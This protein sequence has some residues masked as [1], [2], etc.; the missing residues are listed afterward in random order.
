VDL[1]VEGA[2]GRVAVEIKHSSSV[3]GRDLRGLR[4]FVAGQ[5]ARLGLV[6]N[7][8]VQA[9]RYEENLLGLPLTWL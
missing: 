1:I 5:K 4:D 6:I 8:D 7:S 3:G 9:R 2:F